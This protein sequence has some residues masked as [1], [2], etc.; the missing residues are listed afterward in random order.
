MSPARGGRH[1]GISGWDCVWPWMRFGVGTA[2]SHPSSNKPPV[3]RFQFPN[4]SG[5]SRLGEPG[6]EP[7]RDHHT[8]RRTAMIGRPMPFQLGEGRLQRSP[9]LIGALLPDRRADSP[10]RAQDQLGLASRPSEVAARPAVPRPP[11]R[12]ARDPRDPL[13]ITIHSATHRRR[14]RADHHFRQWPARHAQHQV[15]SAAASRVDARQ[16]RGGLPVLGRWVNRRQG[17]CAAAGLPPDHAPGPFPV[18]QVFSPC[19]G[20]GRVDGLDLAPG[21]PAN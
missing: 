14:D 6:A 3:D 19:L 15:S 13:L 21:G 20:R 11:K 17:C 16:I 1:R 8:V 10:V 12:S 2:G 9:R 7:P 4:R 5:A 18:G